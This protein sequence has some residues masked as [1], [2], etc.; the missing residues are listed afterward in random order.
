MRPTKEVVYGVRGVRT[1]HDIFRAFNMAAEHVVTLGTHCVPVVQITQYDYALLTSDVLDSKSIVPPPAPGA[2]KGEV[3][4]LAVYGKDVCTSVYSKPMEYMIERVGRA[5]PK[6][7]DL[8]AAWDL[9]RG[10]FQLREVM[11]AKPPKIRGKTVDFVVV[12]DV[13]Q[14]EVLQDKE[15][16]EHANIHPNTLQKGKKF[17]KPRKRRR[18]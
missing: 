7:T 3:K 10:E 17:T 16:M 2:Y 8:G 18:K 4:V 12:D 14:M 13:N 15:F 1:A 6:S 9:F 5:T 11:P